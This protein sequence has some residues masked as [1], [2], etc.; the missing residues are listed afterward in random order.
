MQS[1]PHGPNLEFSDNKPVPQSKEHLGNLLINESPI[2][3]NS[4]ISKKLENYT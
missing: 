3:K 4:F 2:A 1:N